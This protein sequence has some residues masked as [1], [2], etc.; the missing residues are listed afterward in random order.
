MIL[1]FFKKKNA[2][3][4]TLWANVAVTEQ[5][6]CEKN[7]TFRLGSANLA[8]RCKGGKGNW[9][10]PE[11]AQY[12]LDRISS[13]LLRVWLLLDESPVSFPLSLTC[14]SEDPLSVSRLVP[15]PVS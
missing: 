10:P 6:K 4:R 5:Q 9:K 15:R 13:T 1:F 14:G 11:V 12:T 3:I 7:E 2:N 8:K